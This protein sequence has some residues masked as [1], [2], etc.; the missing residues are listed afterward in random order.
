MFLNGKDV[1]KKSERLWKATNVLEYRRRTGTVKSAT[2]VLEYRRR[3]GTVKS[4]TNVL[5]Y[6]RRTGTVKSLKVRARLESNTEHY[7]SEQELR[8]VRA[9]LL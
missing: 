2:N 8:S 6:R 9:M 7:R 5:E 4:A 1:V 3:T